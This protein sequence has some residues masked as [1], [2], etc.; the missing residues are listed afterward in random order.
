MSASAQI[1]LLDSRTEVSSQSACNSILLQRS[2][3]IVTR[4]G[5]L[6]DFV[7]V[8]L[9]LAGTG[10]IFPGLRKITYT[11]LSITVQLHIDLTVR[12]LTCIPFCKQL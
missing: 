7:A 1:W 5:N 4:M 6:L 10:I 3:V 12:F 2:R 8:M 11:V 9:T